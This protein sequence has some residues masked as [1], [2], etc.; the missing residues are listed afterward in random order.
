MLASSLSLFTVLNDIEMSNNSAR[1][2]CTVSSL[3]KL[4]PQQAQAVDFDGIWGFLVHAIFDRWREHKL[5]MH[6]DRNLRLGML[7]Y[8]QVSF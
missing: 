7:F 2:L 6:F 8:L 4:F 1:A 3:L 5:C